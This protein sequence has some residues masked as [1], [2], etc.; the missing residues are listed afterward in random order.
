[1]TYEIKL[2]QSCGSKVKQI[3]GTPYHL[4]YGYPF[5]QFPMTLIF[6]FTGT[7]IIGVY[8]SYVTLPL[9]FK[10]NHNVF[11]S[12]Y[13]RGILLIITDFSPLIKMSYCP[14]ITFEK[15]G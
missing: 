10:N 1:M 11:F 3:W 4:S 5:I 7:I 14:A 9:T 12:E 8:N 15:S 2:N 6:P 13:S